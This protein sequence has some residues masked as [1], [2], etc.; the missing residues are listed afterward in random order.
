MQ[1]LLCSVFALLW[2]TLNIYA[3]PHKPQA[4]SCPP[5]T[6]C[7]Q[8]K[9]D[10]KAA[11]LE[12]LEDHRKGTLVE[13][14]DADFGAYLIAKHAFAPYFKEEYLDD[15]NQDDRLISAG[16]MALDWVQQY[17]AVKI[18]GIKKVRMPANE[19]LAIKQPVT[20]PI[21]TILKKIGSLMSGIYEMYGRK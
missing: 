7:A 2:L 18:V 14:W 21:D 1:K 12:V 6:T 4:G 13:H 5:N 11:I 16:M 9:A 10:L 20:L 17:M 8:R 19:L 15:K 3:Q